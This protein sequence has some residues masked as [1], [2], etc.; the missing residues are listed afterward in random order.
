MNEEVIHGI[1]TTAPLVEG[2]MISIDVGASLDGF[3]GDC[4]VTVPVGR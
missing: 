4:A 3:F 2:D 1:P